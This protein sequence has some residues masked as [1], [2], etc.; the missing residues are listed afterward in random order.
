MFHDAVLYIQ[1]NTV[2]LAEGKKAQNNPS[3]TGHAYE[4]RI[5]FD[6]LRFRFCL[7]KLTIGKIIPHVH[8]V[9]VIVIYNSS[10]YS[11]EK[12]VF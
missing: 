12:Y 9:S 7:I 5:V 3:K 1:Y 2:I 8:E 6:I 10:Y 4:M 11:S